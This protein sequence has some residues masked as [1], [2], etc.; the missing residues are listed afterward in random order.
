[1]FNKK[2]KIIVATLCVYFLTGVMMNILTMKTIQIATISIFTC[3]IILTPINF[4]CNDI[5]SECLGEKKAFRVILIGAGI[6][7]VWSIL[8]AICCALPSNNQFISDA[9][10]VI[11]GSTFRITCASIIAF[12]G[13]GWINNRVM[14]RMRNKDGD[15]LFYKRAIISTA[16]GQLVDDYVFVL[17]AFA[18]IGLSAIENPWDAVI[19][20][21][22]ISAIVETCLECLITPV[23][24]KV[25]TSFKGIN[26]ES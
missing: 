21:P 9:F 5:L 22:L 19:T 17:L 3:G 25:C 4:A 20:V 1:M 12:I 11:L 24:K 23:S 6:N 14:A 2:Q 18:P 26:A 13:G 15:R 8:T 7:I 16:F 10:S